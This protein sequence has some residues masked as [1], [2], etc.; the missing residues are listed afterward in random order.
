MTEEQILMQRIYALELQME[1]LQSVVREL[2]DLKL[3]EYLK[4]EK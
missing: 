2:I 1:R 4:G 3:Q